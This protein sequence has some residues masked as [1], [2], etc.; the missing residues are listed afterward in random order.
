MIALTG[1]EELA[2]R[3]LQKSLDVPPPLVNMVCAAVREFVEARLRDPKVRQRY[4][5]QLE[6]ERPLR[7]EP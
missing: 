2:I 1:G 5:A 7:L 6:T 4:N 3:R